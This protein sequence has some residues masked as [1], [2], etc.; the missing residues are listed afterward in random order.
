M[1]L[2]KAQLLIIN[3]SLVAS[4]LKP[5]DKNSFL[6]LAN[7]FPALDLPINSQSSTNFIKDE[8][9]YNYPQN[10]S[11]SYLHY[12]KLFDKNSLYEQLNNYLTHLN[13]IKLPKI[14]N[15]INPILISG[16]QENEEK[17]VY[18]HLFSEQFNFLDKIILSSRIG[19]TRENPVTGDL[20]IGFI[21]Y[22]FDKKYFIERR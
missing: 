1:I 11:R 15:A 22:N 19:M 3:E 8:N 5:K 13:G 17:I 7:K 14:N 9:Y 10:I 20:P 12:L 16:T 4:F 18:L 6:T 21:Y 2:G